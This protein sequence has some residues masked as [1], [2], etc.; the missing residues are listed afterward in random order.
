METAANLFLQCGVAV[1][2]V[3][4]GKRGSFVACNDAE[5]F[6]RNSSLPAS[7][8]D[9]TCRVGSVELPS[10]TILNG[11]GAGDSFT[12]GFL[13]AAM[14]RHTGM[15]VPSATNDAAT[16]GRSSSKPVETSTASS[17]ASKPTKRLTPY[18][19]YMREHYVSLKAQLHDDK[20]AI[21]S[22]CHEMWE[23]E[24]DNVKALY[25]RK[26]LEGSD[27]EVQ[28]EMS[29]KV[30]DEMESLDSTLKVDTTPQHASLISPRNMY[31]TNRSLSLESSVQFASLVA[32]YHVDA[33]TR[34]RSHIDVSQLVERAM[35]V[36]T[37]L[38][39][40]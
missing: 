2:V 14:L 16:A 7:W 20:K 30:M 27:E 15:T 33:S 10:D 38:E 36:S 31:M 6:R 11:N 39:E 32:A 19:L 29:I 17:S 13:V 1:V 23:M 24:S 40:I 4:C 34:D 22:R 26:A 5:R 18:A 35:V 37:R 3:T 8:V 25:E 28:H 12:A 21:F 9:C